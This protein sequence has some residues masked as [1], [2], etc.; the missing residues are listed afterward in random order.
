LKLP[1]SALLIPVWRV[2]YFCIQHRTANT[3]NQ[4]VVARGMIVNKSIIICLWALLGI[5]ISTVK[6]N[7]IMS[8]PA[9][10]HKEKVVISVHKEFCSIDGT[11][12][13]KFLKKPRDSRVHAWIPIYFPSEGHGTE[14]FNSIW[15]ELKPNSRFQYIER[16]NQK[17][18]K[19]SISFSTFQKVFD[20]RVTPVRNPERD[21]NSFSLTNPGGT[22]K[23]KDPLRNP[24][25]GAAIA[26]FSVE[27]PRRSFFRKVSLHAQY[28]Q[29][30]FASDGKWFNIYTPLLPFTRLDESPEINRNPSELPKDYRIEIVPD[31]GMTITLINDQKVIEKSNDRIV[32]SPKDRH[33]ILFEVRA[34]RPED[35]GVRVRVAD[36]VESKP[37]E[38][39]SDV[40]G[41]G[42]R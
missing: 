2:R 33:S 32:I 22:R 35:Q 19:D 38:L 13:F 8:Y 37:K 14:S 5:G 6:A 28:K 40:A 31:P 18:R 34:V 23:S 20:L 11:Y 12:Q 24:P 9:Y 29:G 41:E 15:K 42:V 39:I 26:M 7:L 3:F 25:D 36:L 17:R 4:R 21:I 30:N 16:E 10:L 27:T 1:D